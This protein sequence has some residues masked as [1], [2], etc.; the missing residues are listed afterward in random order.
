MRDRLYDCEDMVKVIRCRDCFFS[1]RDYRYED[2]YACEK[3][4]YLPQ[5]G[6]K[7]HRKLMQG[8][9][10]CSY[11]VRKGGNEREFA[12]K[13]ELLLRKLQELEP[14]KRREE[15]ER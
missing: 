14:L 9:D 8:C 10:Y 5:T 12:E 3:P 4:L 7:P 11:G 2:G 15:N 6:E 13:C 1:H